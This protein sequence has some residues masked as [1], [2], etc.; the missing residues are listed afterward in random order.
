MKPI[1]SAFLILA[2]YSHPSPTSNNYAAPR[3]DEQRSSLVHHRRLNLDQFEGVGCQ[4]RSL[5]DG[6]EVQPQNGRRRAS[7][8]L[9]EARQVQ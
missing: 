2:R 4:P 9:K 8:R 1:V 5:G 3:P 6:D 7:T